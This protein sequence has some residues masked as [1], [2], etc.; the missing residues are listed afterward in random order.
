MDPDSQAS[1]YKT[2]FANCFLWCMSSKVSWNVRACSS[3]LGKASNPG[4]PWST[5]FMKIWSAGPLEMIKIYWIKNKF[6]YVVVLIYLR[7]TLPV[8]TP[9]KPLISPEITLRNVSGVTSW[10]Y[11]FHLFQLELK[12]LMVML[13]NG[14]LLFQHSP[15]V[16]HCTHLPHLVHW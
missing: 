2:N 4:A 15:F 12:N 13:I 14:N 9:F 10:G 7:T 6:K 3:E 11:K 8:P 16:L 1:M 5:K